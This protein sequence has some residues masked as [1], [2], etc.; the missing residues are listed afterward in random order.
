MV[1]TVRIEVLVFAV[2]R[3]V[4]GARCLE[5]EVVAGTTVNSLIASLKSDYPALLPYMPY[6][7]IALNEA[8]I[9]DYEHPLGPGDVVALIPPV[10]GGHADPFLTDEPISANQLIDSVYGFDCGAVVTFEG[11]IRNHTGAHQVLHLD[12]EAYGPM[13][14]AVF[15]ELLIEVEA[16]FPTCRIALRHRLGHLTLGEVAVAIAVV[17]PHRKVAFEACQRLIDRLKEDV[18]IFKKE[19]RENGSIWVGLGP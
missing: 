16:S 12:Y 10:S 2:L 15:T 14:E 7:R 9:D 1:D 6:V 13:A 19:A 18:P 4:L 8:F 3:E 11:R 17:A 5:Q